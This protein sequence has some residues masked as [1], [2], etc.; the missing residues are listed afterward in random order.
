MLSAFAHNTNNFWSLSKIVLFPK[1]LPSYF[2]ERYLYRAFGTW[3]TP[4]VVANHP[5]E[6]H[7]TPVDLSAFPSVWKREN[8]ILH[9]LFGKHGYE[10]RIAGGAVRD[11]LLG[12]NPH[13]IDYATNATP[14]QMNEMFLKENIRTLN[15]NGEAHGTVTVRIE[16]KVNFEITTLRVD[17]EPD[18]RHT[19]VLFTDDWGLDAAR[20]DLTVNSMF[21]GFDMDSLPEISESDTHQSMDSARPVTGRIYDYFDGQNDLKDRRVRFVGDAAARIKEDYLRILRYFRFYGRLS[22]SPDYDV[23]DPDTLKAISDNAKGLSRIAG[24]RCW[25]EL[26]QILLYPSTPTILRRMAHVGVLS[27]LG[28]P[29]SPNFTE[30][31][32][33]WN[34]GILATSPNSATCLA[35][36]LADLDQIDT[37]NNRLRLSNFEVSILGYIVKHREKCINLKKTDALEF[38]QREL[39]LSKMAE[40]KF[41]PVLTEVMKYVAMDPDLYQQWMSWE[42]QKFPVK[43]QIL[44]EK[45]GIP[46]RSMHRYMFALRTQWVDSNCKMTADELLTDENRALIEVHPIVTEPSP[47]RS[48]PK[49]ARR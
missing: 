37:L 31:D 38:Y 20:R 7:V 35:S 28:L 48:H 13:D 34:R 23:H 25:M 32:Q 14:T 17:S 19:K 46:S 33:L 8:V 47:T 44:Q 41:R 45:W 42:P 4:V 27:Y 9:K 22:K 2:T 12:T 21:L 39:L 18:G 15:R 43:G 49:R 26:R 24:E 5:M 1:R 10:L 16:D 6:P 30:M 36:L 3:P 29:S 11:I 40:G